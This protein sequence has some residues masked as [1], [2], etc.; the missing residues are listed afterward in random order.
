V[1]GYCHCSPGRY[2]ATV[3][4]HVSWSSPSN[5]FILHHLNLLPEPEM[6]FSLT[7][8]MDVESFGK[9]LCLMCRRTSGSQSRV[10]YPLWFLSQDHRAGE[11]LW[12]SHRVWGRKAHFPAPQP[13]PQHGVVLLGF[14]LSQAQS[15]ASYH[16]TASLKRPSF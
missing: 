9:G 12:L 14:P 1:W 2:W 16:G 7:Q 11:G 10:L 5:R 15:Q 13:C 3:V 6:S 4:V 8:A